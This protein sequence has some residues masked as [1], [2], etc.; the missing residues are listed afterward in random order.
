MILSCSL[1]TFLALSFVLLTSPWLLPSCCGLRLCHIPQG[2]SWHADCCPGSFSPASL[3]FLA[4]SC[5]PF[6]S[7]RR[8]LVL[9][10]FFWCEVFH[11]ILTSVLSLYCW[12]LNQF[13]VA[14]CLIARSCFFVFSQWKGIPA[15]TSLRQSV[16]HGTNL[17]MIP[18][19]VV[20]WI[21]LIWGAKGRKVTTT[22][23][24]NGGNSYKFS[25]Q[26]KERLLSVSESFFLNITSGRNC[27]DFANWPFLRP[28]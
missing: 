15:Y 25:L 19:T 7:R 4:F 26:D 22:E 9:H 20:L 3:F 11:F 21:Y 12:R 27:Q 14:A 8:P 2:C 6:S 28:G 17:R 10:P 16:L 23:T 18:R 13:S 24:K 1:H 5:V